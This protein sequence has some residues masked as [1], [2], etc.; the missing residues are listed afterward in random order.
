MDDGSGCGAAAFSVAGGSRGSGKC[1]PQPGDSGGGPW[2]FIL[3]RHQ[4]LL[5]LASTP[6]VSV[7]RAG[8]VDAFLAGVPDQQALL[9]CVARSRVVGLYEGVFLGEVGLPGV[10]VVQ[11]HSAA[12][13]VTCIARSFGGRR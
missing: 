12:V 4:G 8:Q 7:A 1:G 10:V 6:W 9:E 3:F 2:V 5:R 13:G 11:A